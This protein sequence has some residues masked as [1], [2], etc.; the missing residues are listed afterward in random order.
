[1]AVGQSEHPK[2]LYNRLPW[3]GS[4]P[5][6]GTHSVLTHSHMFTKDELQPDEGRPIAISTD[7]T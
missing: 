1:M 7:S 6:K 2:S 4:H 3:E 5:Q